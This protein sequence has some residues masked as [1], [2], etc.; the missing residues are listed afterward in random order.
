MSRFLPIN[1]FDTSSL[2]PREQFPAWCES[3]SPMFDARP[4][5]EIAPPSFSGEFEAYLAGPLVLGGTT[6]DRHHYGRDASRIRRD[7]LNHYHL[8]LHLSGGY[9]GRFGDHEVDVGSGDITLMDFG[10]PLV[11]QSQRSE[12]L[13]IAIPREAIEFKITPANHHGL[14]LRGETGLGQLLGDHIRS[15]IARLPAMTADEATAAASGSIAMI[16]ACFQPTAATFAHAKYTLL[17]SL[18]NRIRQHIA[19]KLREGE[20]PSADLCAEFGISRAS[21]Y[22]LFEPFGGVSA[23][24]QNQRLSHVFTALMNPLQNHRTISAIAFEWGFSSET[25]F[26]RAFRKAFGVTPSDARADMQVPGH[27]ASIREWLPRMRRR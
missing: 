25:H 18:R 10:Q 12:L 16:A 4:I 26:S 19:L 14:V 27:Q 24:V 11:L 5:D 13:V 23:Y 6:F 20:I 1:V 9:L 3:I 21:L 22:R 8:N 17:D 15:L 2:P 7:Q